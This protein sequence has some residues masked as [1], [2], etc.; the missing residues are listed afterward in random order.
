MIDISV[1]MLGYDFVMLAYSAVG[2]R[3]ASSKEVLLVQFLLCT[4]MHLNN[5]SVDLFPE[6]T[7]SRGT[8]GKRGS[9]FEASEQ[10]RSDT[11]LE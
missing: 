4:V 6:S 5:C 10:P 1:Q 8:C 2:P 11:C 3:E 7:T 9:D